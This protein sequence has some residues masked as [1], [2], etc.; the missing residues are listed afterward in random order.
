MTLM[1][2]PFAVRD[3]FPNEIQLSIQLLELRYAEVSLQVKGQDNEP[4]CLTQQINLIRSKPNCCEHCL[5]ISYGMDAK[6]T[7]SADS[8]SVTYVL[9]FL[10]L[11]WFKAWD[12]LPENKVHENDE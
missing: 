12:G 7:S 11:S 3:S 2:N 5:R 8:K 9:G 6:A 1:L 10:E 4:L